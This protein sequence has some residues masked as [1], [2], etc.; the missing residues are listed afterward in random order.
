MPMYRRSIRIILLFV[1][2]PVIAAGIVFVVLMAPFI[3]EIPP[4]TYDNSVVT[5]D[6]CT[7]PCWQGL[8]VGESTYY[9]VLTTLQNLLFIPNTFIDTRNYASIRWNWGWYHRGVFNFDDGILTDMH[10]KPNYAFLITDL[11]EQIGEPDLVLARPGGIP[12]PSPTL[13]LYYPSIGV[14]VS[15]RFSRVNH[16]ETIKIPDDLTGYSVSVSEP[17]RTGTDL[18]MSDQDMLRIDAE[19]FLSTYASF[20]WP[21]FGSTLD[22]REGDEMFLAPFIIVSPTPSDPSD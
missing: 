2:W 19:Q 20:G 7:L 4:I 21:G 17:S 3:L 12:D 22:I 8:V 18:Y 10:I 11:F 14:V 1:L 6:P 9:E 16:G 15:A 5:G 13:E